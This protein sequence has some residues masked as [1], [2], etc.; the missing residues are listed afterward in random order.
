M[1]DFSR[2]FTTLRLHPSWP[3][4]LGHKP[5]RPIHFCL[6]WP[7]EDMWSDSRNWPGIC[8]I[9]CCYTPFTRYNRLSN[10]LYNRL[11]N[12]LHRVNKH[13]TGCTTGLT[14]GVTTGW[15]FVYT[16]QPFV[17]GVVRPV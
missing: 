5:C 1:S 13:P 11:D 14:T 17:Q 8:R 9:S 6:A 4:A 7:T 15:M 10:L 12:R 16:I 2:P 3:T